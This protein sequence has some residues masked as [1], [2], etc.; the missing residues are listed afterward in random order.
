LEL[1]N[2]KAVGGNSTVKTITNVAMFAR[3]RRKIETVYT[4]LFIALVWKE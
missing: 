1:P 4:V 2:R 3:K